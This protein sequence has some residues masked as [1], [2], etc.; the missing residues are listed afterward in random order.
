[1]RTRP[2]RSTRTRCS[3]SRSR[4]SL[5]RYCVCMCVFQVF[6]VR[7]TTG[8][9]RVFQSSVVTA[10]CKQQPVSLRA[11]FCIS[12]SSLNNNRRVRNSRCVCCVHAAQSARATRSSAS[13][14]SAEES[15][16]RPKQPVR[17]RDRLL[18]YFVGVWVL[19][20]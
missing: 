16:E 4:Y 6:F 13:A 17:L 2:S 15:P 18:F 1:M 5:R 12:L 3:V 20:M 14:T 8:I 9:R 10:H 7:N 19:F 11:R